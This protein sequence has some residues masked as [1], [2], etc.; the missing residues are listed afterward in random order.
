MKSMKP[1]P[2]LGTPCS[3]QSVNWNCR[4]VRDCPSW[5]QEERRRHGPMTGGVLRTWE[6]FPRCRPTRAEAKMLIPLMCCSFLVYSEEERH[7]SEIVSP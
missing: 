7:L 3:G 5:K 2:D 1:S 6:M 4:T